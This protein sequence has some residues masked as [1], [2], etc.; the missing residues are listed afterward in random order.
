MTRDELIKD[1]KRIKDMYRLKWQTIAIDEAIEALKENEKLKKGLKAIKEEINQ[2]DMHQ[3]KRTEVLKI[4]DKYIK[5][6]KQ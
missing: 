3:F 1:L 4:L 6:N 2:I 5:E